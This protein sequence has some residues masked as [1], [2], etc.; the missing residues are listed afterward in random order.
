[1]SEADTPGQRQVEKTHGDWLFNVRNHAASSPLHIPPAVYVSTPLTEQDVIGL[2]HQLSALGVFPGIKI[3]S[4]SQKKTY[5]CLVEFNC[6]PNEPGLQYSSEG[7]PLGLTPY[8]LGVARTYST[9][10]LTVEFKNNL[11]A[12]IGDID[13][14][15]PKAFAHIDIC[16]CWGTVDDTF[17][18]YALDRVV[19]TNLDERKYPGITH[20]LRHNGDAHVIGVVMLKSIT[21]MILAGQMTIPLTDTAKP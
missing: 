8:V 14:T 2:F 1:M 6:S 18:G 4:T 15:S 7:Y 10:H 21:E 20:L 3:Y 13:G 12:L 11:D 5:D 9:R 19:E 16:V 17:P